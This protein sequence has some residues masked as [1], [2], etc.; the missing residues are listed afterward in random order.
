MTDR[1]LRDLLHERV[2]DLAAPDLSGK[3]WERAG[4]IRRRRA[5]GVVVGA[6]ASVAAVAVAIAGVPG[7]GSAGGPGPGPA[8]HRHA[9]TAPSVPSGPARTG[10][11]QSWPGSRDTTPDGRHGGWPVYRGPTASQE[12]S[13]PWIGSPFPQAVDLSAPAPDVADR[14]IRS[15]LAAYAVLDDAGGTRLLLLAPDGTLRSVNTSPV[16]PYDD[17]AGNDISIAD[18]NLLSPT[19]EY[20]AFP[21]AAGQVRVLTLATGE[22][23][24]IDTGRGQVVTMQWMGDTDLW[25]PPTTQGGQGPMYSAFDG[26][27]VGVAGE[28]APLAPFDPGAG[29]YG[30]WRMGPLG[31]AQSWGGIAGLPVAG[32]RSTPTQAVVVQGYRT[33]DDALLVLGADASSDPQRPEHC[34]SVEFWLDDDT[35]AFESGAPGAPQRL[36]AWKVGTHA[37]TRVATLEGYDPDRQVVVSSYARVWD[38]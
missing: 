12:E 28:R 27:R 13:L 22:W 2:D 10:T 15:A 5:A 38:R 9:P 36:V 29:P 16:G 25:F 35:V 37:L 1:E 23:R 33:A 31:T 19:G 21:Q 24:T 32:D 34:C 20:L 7:L 14:P 3:A 4:R 11:T 8:T 30:R 6:V 17:G 26:S 18:D